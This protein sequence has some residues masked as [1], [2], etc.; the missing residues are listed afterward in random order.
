LLD[1]LEDDHA[2]LQT[3]IQW[4]LASEKYGN[5][6]LDLAGSL[7]WFWNL[8]SHFTEGLIEVESTFKQKDDYN[9]GTAAAGKA[10]FCAGGLSF[11]QGDINKAYKYLIQSINIWK[12]LEN[13]PE[14]SPR[15]HAFALIILSQVYVDKKESDKAHKEI[16]KSIGLLK[17]DEWGSA[18]ALNDLGNVLRSMEQYGEALVKYKESLTL[19]KKLKDKWGEPLTRSNIGFVASLKG[20]YGESKKQLEEAVI[21]QTQMNDKWGLAETLKCLGDV[22]IHLEDWTKANNYYCQS[23]ELNFVVGRKQLVVACLEGMAIRAATLNQME[24]AVILFEASASLHEKIGVF[25]NLT[26]KKLKIYYEH[27]KDKVYKAFNDPDLLES[28]IEKGK[29]MNLQDAAE[30]VLSLNRSKENAMQL[31]GG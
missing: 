14:Y 11:L 23:I 20:D 31:V 10:F 3:A 26:D 8:H 9:L 21:I 2:N 24:E 16:S 19:W 4:S 12:R 6:S 28:L 7:F 22:S 29:N 25:L 17:D 1:I 13:K 27:L 30:Y 15:F 18:L 5:I